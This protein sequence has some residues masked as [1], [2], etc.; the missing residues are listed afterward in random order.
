MRCAAW[1]LP[2]HRDR[3]DRRLQGSPRR[4]ALIEI[5]KL[6]GPLQDDAAMA[7]GKI[8]DKNALGVLAALQQSAP[9]ETQPAI[10]AAICLMGTNCSSHIGYLEK[11]LDVRGHL[12]RLPGSAARRRAGLGNIARQGNE[13]RSNPVRCRHPVAGSG[14]RAGHAGHRPGRAPQHA[15]DVEDA[16]RPGPIRRRV[17]HRRRGVR[18]ARGGSRGGAVLRRRSKGAT[19]P[20]PTARRPESCANS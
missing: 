10:A 3:S 19:G 8:G 5:A 16:S 12:S 4:S 18:H 15:A 20:P 6:E 14:A 2:Q 7:I 17:R 9:K 1:I 11:T 13:A